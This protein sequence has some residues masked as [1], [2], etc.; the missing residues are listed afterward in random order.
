VLIVG[1]FK[2]KVVLK[3]PCTLSDPNTLEPSNI[4]HVWEYV[5]DTSGAIRVH[6]RAP[7]AP[8]TDDTLSVVNEKEVV[9]QPPSL[10]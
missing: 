8:D 4:E 3:R 5:Q 9:A 6:R 7:S 1:A 10:S 2:L